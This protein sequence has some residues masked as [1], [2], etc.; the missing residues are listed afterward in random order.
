MWEISLLLS[1]TF[2]F[3][4]ARCLLAFGVYLPVLSSIESAKIFEADSDNTSGH[5]PIQMTLNFT[6]NDNSLYD[7]D[8]QCSEK[9]YKIFWSKFS[10]VDINTKYVTLLLYDL[11]KGDINPTDS[12]RA[13]EK[14]S[15]LQHIPMR[16]YFGDS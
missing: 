13:A 14:I 10:L 11:E 16:I 4:I 12:E 5:L 9:K 8:P 1:I 15:K 7:G 3:L 2:L 6:M